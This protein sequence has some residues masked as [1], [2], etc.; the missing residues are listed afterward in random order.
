[1]RKSAKPSTTRKQR[2]AQLK[3]HNVRTAAKPKQRADKLSTKSQTVAKRHAKAQKPT[4]KSQ[5]PQRRR[6]KSA[7]LALTKAQLLAKGLP[8]PLSMQ[9]AELDGA[10]AT[11]KFA[12][13][14][15]SWAQKLQASGF[16]DIERGIEDTPYLKRP[17]S[18]KAATAPELG[19]L[20]FR[21]ARAMLEHHNWQRAYDLP[22]TRT[23]PALRWMP[24]LGDKLIWRLHCDGATMR[25]IRRQYNIKFAGQL[26][27][28]KSG[29]VGKLGRTLFYVY[30]RL[31]VLTAVCYRW[32]DVHSEGLNGPLQDI[33][34]DEVQFYDKHTVTTAKQR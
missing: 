26:R 23:Q 25:D 8:V 5:K 20:H 12:A 29:H 1:V 10:D 32:N 3:Q 33:F 16:D 13:L 30:K 11:A 17:D 19:E 14:Q 27:K 15:Q 34:A 28:R 24:K 9:L 2:A 4:E 21:M 18:T 22:A 6:K 31:K 7:Q